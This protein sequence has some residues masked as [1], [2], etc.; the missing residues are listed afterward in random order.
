MY[1]RNP[2][3]AVIDRCCLIANSSTD[4]SPLDVSEFPLIMEVFGQIKQFVG[5]RGILLT[6]ARCVVIEL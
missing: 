2:P 3:G 1:K 4:E 6:K 5:T